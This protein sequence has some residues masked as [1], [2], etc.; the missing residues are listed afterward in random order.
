MAN[1][2]TF[3][4][5]DPRAGRR[6]GVQNRAT[7]DVRAAIARVLEGNAENFGRWL[8]K[9]A[10]GEKE[11]ATDKKGKPIVDET[12]APKMRWLRKPDPGYAVKLAMDMAEYHIPKL[13]RTEISGEIGVRGT[14][15]I[16][17]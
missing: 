2:G 17:D 9:V 1:N 8:A 11:P 13:A 10:E 6:K 7:R 4:P 15:T 12:G 14:L 16:R 3:K 5:G